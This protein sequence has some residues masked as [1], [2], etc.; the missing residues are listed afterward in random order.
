[1]PSQRIQIINYTNVADHEAIDAVRAMVQM[2]RWNAMIKENGV[3]PVTITAT[4]HDKAGSVY[5]LKSTA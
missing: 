2:G 4:K 3:V 1:M 5:T